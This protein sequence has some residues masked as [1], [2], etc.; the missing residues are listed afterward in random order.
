MIREGSHVCSFKIG[1]VGS[2]AKCI[3]SSLAVKG[4]NH[5]SRHWQ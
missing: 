3:V 4:K 5:Y 2:F 1:V